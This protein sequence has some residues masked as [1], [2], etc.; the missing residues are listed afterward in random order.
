MGNTVKSEFCLK[1]FTVIATKKQFITKVLYFPSTDIGTSSGQLQNVKETSSFNSPTFH[2]V[3]YLFTCLYKAISLFI[4]GR[5]FNRL[6][7]RR[8]D[9]VCMRRPSLTV[10]KY[11]DPAGF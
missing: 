7:I 2:E 9:S 4:L 6:I 8:R 5:P 3:F 1:C 11:R 10:I